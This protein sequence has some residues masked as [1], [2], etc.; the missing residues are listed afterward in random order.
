MLPYAVEGVVNVDGHIH[1]L[2][3][4]GRQVGGIV[5]IYREGYLMSAVAQNLFDLAAH[6]PVS[7]YGGFHNRSEVL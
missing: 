4:L 3:I 5:D 7:Y 1:I 2:K 6:L